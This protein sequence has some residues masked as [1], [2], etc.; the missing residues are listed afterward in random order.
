MR[1]EGEKRRG[2]PGRGASWRTAS[3]WA[4]EGYP[5]A[6]QAHGMAITAHLGGEPGSGRVVR[7]RR[8]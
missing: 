5:S 7:G 4:G 3:P 1:A 6:P 8:P 2:R